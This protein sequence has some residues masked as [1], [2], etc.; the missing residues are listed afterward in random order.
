MRDAAQAQ[1]QQKA[2]AELW[3]HTL[4]Q[5]HCQFGRL[6]YLSSL[7][8]GNTGVYEHHG[9]SLV[10]GTEQA[11]RTLQDS[12]IECFREWLGLNLR[13]QHADL[14]LYF[15]EQD[16][17]LKVIVGT[18]SRL[19]SYRNLI[20]ASAT[21]TERQLFLSDLETLLAMLKNACDAED[22]DPNA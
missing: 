11:G 5:I 21:A 8:N 17:E 16:A 20:P 1:G 9:L 7:R 12:H 13:E 4:S 2:A 22:T 18:W 10:L 15:S 6:V 19:A 14:S 3:K